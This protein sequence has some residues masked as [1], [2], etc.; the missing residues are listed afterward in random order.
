MYVVFRREIGH[1]LHVCKDSGNP[2][3]Y[4]LE[5]RDETKGGAIVTRLEMFLE[6]IFIYRWYVGFFLFAILVLLGIHG[7]SIGIYSAILHSPDTALWGTNRVIRSD[8]W[9]INTPLAFSQYFNGFAY[10]S[11][12][13][14]GTATDM[15]MVY[16]QPVR[17]FMVIFRPFQLGYLFLSPAGGLAF[18][19]MGRLIVTAQ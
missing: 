5:L 1:I 7:S 4:F 12:I 6:K 3:C 14:R 10:F 18:F 17:D 13:V 8:E 11:D 15:F 2:Y 19:W 16:A 9:M